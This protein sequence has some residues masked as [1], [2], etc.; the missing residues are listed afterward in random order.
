MGDEVAAGVKWIL[1]VRGDPGDPGSDNR[2]LKELTS[3]KCVV[4]NREVEKLG[5]PH[6]TQ[7]HDTFVKAP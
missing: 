3:L 1:G 2:W 4:S 7:Y 6:Y 5:I